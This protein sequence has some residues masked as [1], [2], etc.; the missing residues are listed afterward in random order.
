MIILPKEDLLSTKENLEK[1]SQKLNEF[2][3]DDP[4]FLKKKKK[5][6]EN[7]KFLYKRMCQFLD[8][9]NV[10]LTNQT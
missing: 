2:I 3:M 9:I 5:E 7:W 6:Q 4:L 8:A 1:D 10:I